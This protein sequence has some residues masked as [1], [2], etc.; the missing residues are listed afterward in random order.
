MYDL[1]IAPSNGDTEVAL[2]T[3]LS[4]NPAEGADGYFVTVGTSPGGSDILNNFEVINSTTLEF[5]QELP[6]GMTIYVTIIP[7]NEGG[8]PEACIEESFM[9]IDL[10]PDQK[11]G[12]SPNG[13]FINDFWEIKEIEN[14]PDNVVSIYN[15]WGELVFEISGYDNATRVFNGNANKATG[16]G[17]SEL[18][19]G[20]YFF[21]INITEENNLTKAGYV[22]IK[23]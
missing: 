6:E 4:W 12:F 17:A 2:D 18:P 1:T 14:F 8:M 15:R 13:D 7:F 9:L 16:K 5:P 19:E 22:V 3:T 11:L 21:T 20:T 10:P 23:R